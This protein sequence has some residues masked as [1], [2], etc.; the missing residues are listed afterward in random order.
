[1]EETF[2]DQVFEGE[3]FPAGK[4]ARCK[5]IDCAFKR[6]DLSNASVRGS[7]FRDV[8]FEDSKLLG[9]N[10]TEA[11]ALARLTFRRSVVTLGNFT[12]L[13]LRHLRLEECVAREVELGHANLTEA[14][15]QK[16]DFKGATFLQTN[17]TKADLRHALNYAIRPGD[18]ILKKAKFSLPEATSLLYGLD[19]VLED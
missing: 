16:T 12:G 1:M 6:C 10:W 4:L 11:K 7:S 8:V 3:A 19:I 14:Y 15:C 13:D 18:N 9:V 2:E 5:F 17:L